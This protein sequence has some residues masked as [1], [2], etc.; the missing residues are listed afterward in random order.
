MN[1]SAKNPIPIKWEDIAGYHVR[2]VYLNKFIDIVLHDEEKY[3]DLMTTNVR[4]LSKL[5][6]AMNAPLFSI[7]WG[8]IKRRERDK[9]TKELDRRAFDNIHIVNEE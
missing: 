4:R 9:L 8:Q 7:V 3:L 1:A 5:N 2:E 6:Q